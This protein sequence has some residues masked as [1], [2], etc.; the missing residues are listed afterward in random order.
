MSNYTFLAEE[1]TI[2]L[3][4]GALGLELAL[5]YDMLRMIRRVF[6]CRFFALACMDMAFWGFTA[7][8]TFFVMHTYSNG[9]LR[10]F[11]VFGVLVVVGFYMKFLSKY[12]LFLGVSI[13]SLVRSTF[14]KVKKCLTNILKLSIIKLTGNRKRGEADGKSSSISDKVP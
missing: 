1:S 3:Y 13:L 14:L 2:L 9:T 5:C 12:I 6:D 8:R 7:F 10:W 11:A 4:S